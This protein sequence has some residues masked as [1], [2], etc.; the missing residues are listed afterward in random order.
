LHWTI[1]NQ[2]VGNVP[3]SIVPAGDTYRPYLGTGTI[4]WCIYS[5]SGI[6]ERS[7]LTNRVLGDMASSADGKYLAASGYKVSSGRAGFY[8]YG[9]VY[10]FDRGGLLKWNVST[11]REILSVHI[12]SNGSVIV[13]NEPELI[14]IN[15]QGSVL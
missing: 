9:V 6:L 7:Y 12:N 10:L 3:F 5:N 4:A 13:A 11:T 1:G 8:G 14:Y 2:G 15:S